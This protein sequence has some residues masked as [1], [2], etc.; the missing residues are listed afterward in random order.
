MKK[1]LIALALV[2]VIV[3][4][5]F[6]FAGCG[7][8]DSAASDFE[9]IKANG[10]LV[11]GYTVFEP[12][13]Y[14]TD[15]G[16][17]VGFDTEFAQEVCAKLGLTPEFTIIDWDTKEVELNAKTIDV[18]WNGFTVTEEG[19]E[20]IDFT[21][22]YM[23]NKQCVVTKAANA[24]NYSSTADLD[25]LAV[26]AEKGSAGE[27]A[28]QADEHL[29]KNYVAVQA[30]SNTLLE[31]KS[32]T[33]DAAVLDYIMAKASV[34]EDTSYSDLAI[35]DGIDLAYEEYAIGCRKGSDLDEQI[36]AAIAELI[37]DG[38]LQTIAD[39]YELGASLIT[40]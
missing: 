12:M 24:A 19:K 40:E 16:T 37:S 9:T 21:K 4:L 3:A 5:T 39:K 26:V 25:G 38:T 17:L 22:S 15:D 18:I 27:D 33:A 23:F 2:T 14:T 30:Q 28:V 20:N 36:N 35:V 31:V 10:K 8:T 11:I 34:G 1:K 7:N 13:N 32:G 6:G 29:S